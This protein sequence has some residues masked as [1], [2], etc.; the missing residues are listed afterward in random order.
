MSGLGPTCPCG[1]VCRPGACL[2]VSGP[3]LIHALGGM[4]N[5]NM[6]CWYDCTNSYSS[7]SLT[8][9]YK[10]CVAF[11]QASGCDWRLLRS[12]P[13]NSRSISG[14]SSGNPHIHV[15]SFCLLI[16]HYCRVHQF[17]MC[18]QVEACRLYSKFSAR[19][20]SL[21]VIPSVVEKVL[22]HLIITP[23]LT[24]DNE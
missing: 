14:V 21:E 15:A 22:Y 24:A 6:N 11:T 3:G 13:G 20:S 12:E 7:L 16:C 4:A 8:R 18:H 17:S 5:A 23:L 2:V 10:V 19:P 1:S 9:A